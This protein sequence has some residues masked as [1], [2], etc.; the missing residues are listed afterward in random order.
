MVFFGFVR[1]DFLFRFVLSTDYFVRYFPGRMFNYV[2][3]RTRRLS[4]SSTHEKYT[5]LVANFRDSY[6]N[7]AQLRIIFM[8]HIKKM[9]LGISRFKRETLRFSLLRRIALSALVHL[10]FYHLVLWIGSYL[11][12]SLP[13]EFSR[14]NWGDDEKLNCQG[15]IVCWSVFHAEWMWVI[16]KGTAANENLWDCSQSIIRKCKWHEK[17]APCVAW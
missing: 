8:M 12:F 3:V 9:T 2:Y 1:L 14:T 16:R 17:C 7:I 5:G 6:R 11:K 13:F 4:L 10:H 15:R